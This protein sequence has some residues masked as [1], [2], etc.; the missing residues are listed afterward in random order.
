MIYFHET[1][2]NRWFS[3]VTQ[4]F[5]LRVSF[6]VM[7]IYCDY[8]LN[9]IL[10][11]IGVYICLNVQSSKLYDNKCII[12]STQI[13]N[14]EIFAFIAVLVFRSSH[15]RCSMAKGVLRNFTKFTGKHLCQSLFLD[16]VAGLGLQL[17]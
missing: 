13:T 4:K 12:A 17:Y 1:I 11:I 5:E 14:A 2:I 8:F 16:E 15:H 9:T 10:H 6:R 7:C 3:G